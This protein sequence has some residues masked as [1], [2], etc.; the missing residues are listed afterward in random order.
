VMQNNENVNNEV[1]MQN[2]EN[3]VVKNSGMKNECI[4][5]SNQG[6]PMQTDELEIAFKNL[7][8]CYNRLNP[9]DRPMKLRKMNE[10]YSDILSEITLPSVIPEKNDSMKEEIKN[11]NATMNQSHLHL[12]TCTCANCP[13]RQELDQLSKFYM[14]FLQ[15]DNQV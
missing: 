6:S 3:E 13:A 14:E 4:P 9:T 10:Q 11:F 7:V 5:E 2:D 12:D 8:D 1:V 15:E